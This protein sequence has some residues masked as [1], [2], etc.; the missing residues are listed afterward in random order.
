M[1]ACISKTC[2]GEEHEALPPLLICKPASQRLTRTI[3]EMPA[4][5]DWLRANLTPGAASTDAP[6]SGSRERPIPLAAGVY[7]HAELI[8]QTLNGWARIVAEDRQL[9]GPWRSLAQDS[10]AERD[11]LARGKE[12]TST[13]NALAVF[14]LA[15]LDWAMGQTWVDDLTEEMSDLARTGHGLAPTKPGRH[16]LPAPCPDCDLMALA[17]WDGEDHVICRNCHAMWD[18]NEYK[19]LVIV[20]SQQAS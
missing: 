17:R 4:L 6:V 12:Q 10:L 14:L 15:H 11:R 7:D 2:R 1:S 3:G 20:L 19:R 8:R 18:E 9:T 16:D 13:V 5:H